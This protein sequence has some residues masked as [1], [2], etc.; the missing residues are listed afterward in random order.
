MIDITR[1][2][3]ADFLSWLGLTGDVLYEVTHWCLLV[4]SLL[5]S[6]LCGVVASCIF[7]PVIHKLVEKSPSKI[8]DLLL[9]DYVLRSACRIVP[10]VVFLVLAP[11]CFE[12]KENNEL[13]YVLIVRLSEVYLTVMVLSLITHILNN[14]S[15]LSA[16]HDKLR[17]HY[18][19]GLVQFLKLVFYSLGV[20]V[21]VAIV[22][23]RSPISLIAGL[24]AAATVMMLLFRDSIVGLVAGIQL[25][26]NDMLKPGD[27]ITVKKLGVD[28]YVQKVS[29]TT[30]KIRNFDNTIATVPPS[31]LVTDSFM[32]WKEIG[33]RGRRVKR[34]IYIDVS[35]VR[36]CSTEELEAYKGL[37]LVTRDEIDMG[38]PIVNLTV[39]RRFIKS[40]LKRHSVVNTDDWLMVRQ[41][42][43]TQNGLP[44]ELYFY[45]K[46]SDFVRYE[47]L[48]AV[49]M[50]YI[51]ASAAQFKVRLYQAPSGSD[52]AG[53][54]RS[55]M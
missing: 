30:M 23:D 36:F 20:I 43:H 17:N 24:G 31:I 50:E 35:T 41:L 19:V 47:E 12:N 1:D 22:I 5:F 40:Y 39:Y 2:Y 15:N 18:V 51:I 6:L 26:V 48:A 28:G 27:W 53:L 7:R 44:I 34:V 49:A 54:T 25:N 11:L 4:V 52:L 45:F 14:V 16:T 9:N 46:E 3:I 42:E 13:M 21:I 32:N 29:L 38:V 55:A 10:A 8:D 37:D 33:T